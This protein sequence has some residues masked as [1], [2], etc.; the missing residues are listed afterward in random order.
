MYETNN[1]YKIEGKEEIL[2]QSFLKSYINEVKQNIIPELS[3]QAVSLSA[4]LWNLLRQRDLHQ[5]DSKM[6]KVL[7]VT[8]RTHESL[9]RLSTAHAKLLKMPY[10]EVYNVI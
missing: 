7:P 3:D 5:K 6:T 2:T 1:V 10:V 9:I 8:I 4:A